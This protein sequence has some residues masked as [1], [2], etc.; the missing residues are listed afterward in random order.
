MC[1]VSGLLVLASVYGALVHGNTCSV[2]Y[3]AEDF[4]KMWIFWVMT[5]RVTSVFSASWFQWYLCGVSLPVFG[6]SLLLVVQTCR[7]LWCSTV[8]VL[9][10]GGDM[11]V[12]VYDRSLEVP[13]VQSC[14]YGRRCD[15]A[16]TSWGLCARARTPRRHPPPPTLPH[17]HTHTTD[18]P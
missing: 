16:A 15:N 17:T 1:F 9:R 18:T 8:E 4:E 12:V 14:G 3:V 6:I 13:E 2:L 5:S 7:K 10:H 11:P